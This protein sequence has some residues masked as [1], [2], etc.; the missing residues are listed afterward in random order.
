MKKGEKGI[1]IFAPMP[2]RKKDES[3][4]ENNSEDKKETTMIGFKVV[5]VFDVAQ[6]EGDALP[7]QA[8]IGGDVGNNLERLKQVV[9][10]ASIDLTFEEL[11]SVNGYSAGG[12]IVVNQSLS[13]AEAFQTM[14]HELAHERLHWG[15][16]RSEVTKTV[17]ETE[18]EAVGY[19]VSE[20]F[21]LESVKHCAD[22]IQLYNGDAETLRASLKQI[23][24]TAQWIIDSIRATSPLT[25]NSV[26]GG[27]N[28]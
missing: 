19:I 14:A 8:G 6:T 20:A 28:G 25:A 7:K 1:A 27:A 24:S 23:Q 21:G 2:F 15:D 9:T 18:A 13:N 22:Y 17:R 3:S 16:R 26:K 4:S 10:Q 5:H 12:K 11:G